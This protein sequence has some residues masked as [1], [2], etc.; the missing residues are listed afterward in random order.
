MKLAKTVTGDAAKKHTPIPLQAPST[1]SGYKNATTTFD[2]FA[3]DNN[4]PK[5]DEL[6]ADDLAGASKNN[7]ECRIPPIG[8]VFA[9]FAE[10][11]TKKVKTSKTTV[12]PQAKTATTSAVRRRSILGR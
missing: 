3:T 2:S 7:K 1:D 10:Y 8:S 4:Y 12:T 11:L 5:L 9:E 6:T